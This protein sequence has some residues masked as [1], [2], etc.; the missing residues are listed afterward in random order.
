[1]SLLHIAHAED[2]RSAISGGE[3]R[4]STRGASLDEVG[5]IHAS[6]SAQ[7]AGVAGFAY[8]GDQEPLVVLVIDDAAVRDAGI[9][10][11]YQDAGN[12]TLYPH[13]FG[14]VRAE[15]VTE[16]R[17]AAFVDGRFCWLRSEGQ[18]SFEGT[19]VETDVAGAVAAEHALL[20]P[21]VRADR[22]AVDRLLAPGFTEIGS[23][24]RLWQR[25]EVLALDSLGA[26][27]GIATSEGFV[28]SGLEARVPAA[29]LVLLSYVATQAGNVTL[30]SSLWR[31]TRHGWQI[32]FHQGT[33]A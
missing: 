29:R 1:M 7:V 28:V 6:T 19:I 23:S 16:V 24:G 27:G 4:V 11:R 30:R 5:F 33:L 2:W 8:A 14:A 25:G 21:A 18:V 9:A 10:V 12:G 32:E 20:D 22:A 13:I 26:P 31:S 15:F 17:E 3:Y